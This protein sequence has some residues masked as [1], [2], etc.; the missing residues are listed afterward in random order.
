MQSVMQIHEIS[1]LFI[2]SK[3]ES[4]TNDDCRDDLPLKLHPNEKYRH[5]M[6][7][8]VEHVKIIR[9]ASLIIN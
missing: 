7:S 1:S 3:F 8:P 4:T 9:Y 6:N 2:S 5:L